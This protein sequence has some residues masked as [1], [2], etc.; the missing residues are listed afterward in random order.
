MKRFNCKQLVRALGVALISTA[1][2]YGISTTPAHAEEVYNDGIFGGLDRELCMA[3][4]Y[5]KVPK[6]SLP[7]DT[8]GCQ[9]N[10][11]EITAVEN[12][13][14]AECAEGDLV[15][16][17]ADVT[18]RTNANERY[19][20][21][22]YLPLTDQSPDDVSIELGAGENPNSLVFPN[23]C[24]IVLPDAQYATATGQT[25]AELDGDVC[26]D[27]TKA[28]GSD[29]Y[30]LLQQPMTMLCQDNDDDGQA[31]FHYCA[32][33]DNQERDN[34]TLDGDF[35]GQV[36]NTK[37]KCN[38]DTLNIPIFI[39]PEP[40]TITKTI[41]GDNFA[42]EPEGTFKYKVEIT[43]VSEKADVFVKEVYDEVSSTTDGTVSA[44]FDLSTQVNTTIGNLTLL[45]Q[46]ADHTCD[47]A[48]ASLPVQLTP[49]SSS[50]DCIAVMRINDDDGPD[51]GT[52]EL[53]QDYIRTLIWDKND[54]VVGEPNCDPTAMPPVAG[55]CSGIVE[56]EIR[57]VDPE[58]DI[59]KFAID[60]PGFECMGNSFDSDG[61]C[62]NAVYIDE[63]G[64][65][66]TFKLIIKNLSTV[67]PL[68]I[69]SLEDDVDGS[70]DDLLTDLS[71]NTCDDQSLDL[72]IAGEVGDTLTC[73]FVRDVSGGLIAVTNT[74]TVLAVESTD[75]SEGN[76]A[77][78]NDSET[79]NIVDV[80]PAVMF[81]KEV[82]VAG[83]DDSSYS[84]LAQVDEPG[85]DVVYRFTIENQ[86]TSGEDITLLSL[87]DDQLDGPRS[88]SGTNTCVLDGSQTI[89]VGPANAYQCTIDAAVIGDAGEDLV[90]VA[91][92]TITDGES[93]LNSLTDTATVE[94]LD[95]PLQITPQVAMKATIFVRLANGGVDTVT[96]NGFELA[97]QAVAAGNGTADFTILDDEASYEYDEFNSGFAFCG[98]VTSIAVGA[99]AECAIPLRLLPGFNV[100]NINMISNSLTV[101][102]TDGDTAAVDVSIVDVS[103]VTVE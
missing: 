87:T 78:D 72:A 21:T 93:N 81:T 25:Y 3:D 66:V 52:A 18:I 45:A 46:H 12:P 4:A 61:A 14:V 77:T 16:F 49:T 34:C 97:G 2:L 100:Q 101:N 98:D 59:K 96:V 83:A 86:S 33:W 90:N 32:A 47:E 44:T 36:P 35:P 54:D 70:I 95:V 40:P 6:N 60:G 80:P 7:Q 38:C 102:V 20:T 103:V 88:T 68:T 27:I 1:S 58:I 50:V 10:D 89:A 15:M 67:D 84:D 74:A 55:T 17:N 29:S 71:G 56:V 30:T 85:G 82:K 99:T 48:F 41:V 26:A 31:D 65:D 64:G 13:S 8:L 51:D 11:V 94:F 24:S 57:D 75:H 23:Y 62:N 39:K 79:V 37:S 22:F 92:V 53:Y 69:T 19:D 91:Y 73:Q 5:L 76:S 43:S 63:P 42:N 9:A 28:Y